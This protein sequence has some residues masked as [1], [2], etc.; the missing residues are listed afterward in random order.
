MKSLLPDTRVSA[1]SS[2]FFVPFPATLFDP[3]WLLRFFKVSPSVHAISLH[4][5]L[6]VA[7]G[8]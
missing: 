4:A 3:P 7:D 5:R 8:W 1:L 2:S 6:L